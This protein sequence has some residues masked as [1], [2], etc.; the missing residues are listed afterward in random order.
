M[1][2]TESSLDAEVVVKHHNLQLK[3]GCE[4]GTQEGIILSRCDKR[5]HSYTRRK[6]N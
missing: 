2:I 3:S 1:C 5:R 6:K 4:S